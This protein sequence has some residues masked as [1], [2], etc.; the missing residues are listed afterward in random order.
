[1]ARPTKQQQVE[2]Q[3]LFLV[4]AS[5]I[6][7]F[8]YS[9]YP[10]AEADD[11][12]QE[13]FLVV[14]KK[15]DSFRLGTDFLAWVRKI[16]RYKVLEH[17]R[18]QNRA[19]AGALSEATIERLADRAEPFFDQWDERRSALQ[20]CLGRLTETAR[21]LVDLKYAEGKRLEEIAAIVGWTAKA[22]KTGLARAR[23]ALRNCIALRTG[24]V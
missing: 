7:G 14:T 15:A 1:M 18:A 10:S 8:I 3:K 12:L 22:V 17:L 20:L 19:S 21:R 23:A 2:V 13:V 5:L 4:N 24:D 11:L 6:H 16:A 9:L